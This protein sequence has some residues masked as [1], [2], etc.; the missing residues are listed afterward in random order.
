MKHTTKLL[1]LILLLSVTVLFSCDD[2]DRSEVYRMRINHFTQPAIPNYGN[3]NTFHF[4]QTGD[5]IGSDKW[6]ML[7]QS[8][9]GL[10]YELGYTYD[11]IVKRTDPDPEWMDATPKY[12]VVRVFSKKE[13][14]ED[15]SFTITLGRG[16]PLTES[17]VTENAGAF[18]T[19]DGIAIRCESFCDEI[20]DMLGSLKTNELL[21]GTFRHVDGQTIS[22]VDLEI[23][24][25]LPNQD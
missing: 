1:S 4:V 20:Q 7:G 22:L 16:E 25:L 5:N 6:Q 11:I 8:I 13:V 17:Y 9:S 3:G 12:T 2:D 18:Q 24:G 19:V 14:A 23:T 21:R 15:I 10:D